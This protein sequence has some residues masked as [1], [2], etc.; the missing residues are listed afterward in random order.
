MTGAPDEHA[1]CGAS[2]SRAREAMDFDFIVVGAG[3]AGC[4]LVYKLLEKPGHRVL[5]VEAGGEHDR[6]F[7]NMPMGFSLLHDDPRTDWMYAQEQPSNRRVATSSWKAGKLLGGSSSIN[8]MV[9]VR[10]QPEDYDDWARFGNPGWGWA[11][12]LPIFKAMEDHELGADDLRGVGGPLPVTC[13]AEPNALSD[14]YIAA[15]VELGLPRRDDLNREDQVGIG[16]YQRTIRRGRRMSAAAAFLNPVRNKP[17]LTVMTNTTVR[18]ILIEGQRAIGIE[19]VLADGTSQTFTAAREIILSAGAIGSPKLLQLSGIGPGSLLNTLG[20]GIVRDLP[21]VGANLQEHLCCGCV[22]KVRHGSLNSE[23]RGVRLVKN[24]ARYFLFRRGIMAMAAAQVGAFFKT[25]RDLARANA[26]LFMAPVCMAGKRSPDV[27]AVSAPEDKVVPATIGGLTSFG[28]PARPA[29]GGNV[30]IQSPD[31]NAKPLIR[32]E[33]LRSDDDKATTVAIIR[34]IRRF[35]E[36]PALAAYGLEEVLPGPAVQSDEALLDFAVN[37][38]QLAYHPAGTC[39]M[40]S[41]R[42]AVVNHELKVVGI[43]GL[44]VAD[45]SVMPLLTSGNTNAPSM[46]IGF[47][48]GTMIAAEHGC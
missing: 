3:S 36:Q 2:G 38:G 42:M 8:G 32:Y 37:T 24:L 46:M 18:R 34:L 33:H 44:R 26:Q 13:T 39:K 23:L 30:M 28:C 25:R 20:I 31:F 17:Q 21:G 1:L 47:K 7:V 4:T 15:G 29:P 48:A 35:A 22:H 11:D 9:Y 43:A 16:Y 27:P 5:L 19:C 45:A 6:L 10:G 14:A 41:D 12:V 40:G